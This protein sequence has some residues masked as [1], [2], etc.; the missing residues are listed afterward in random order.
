MLQDFGTG[1]R[2]PQVVFA[3]LRI[4]VNEA[5]PFGATPPRGVRRC[6]QLLKERHAGLHNG[7]PAARQAG[8]RRCGRH[9][10]S[11]GLTVRLGFT[12]AIHTDVEWRRDRCRRLFDRFRCFV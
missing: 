9:L 10:D 1:N 5:E 6:C 2:N 11:F 7:S 3:R 8:R 12:R 4:A